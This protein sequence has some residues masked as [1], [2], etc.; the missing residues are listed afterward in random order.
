MYDTLSNLRFWVNNEDKVRKFEIKL[1]AEYMR[2]QI[3]ECQR[4][5]N[6]CIPY[7]NEQEYLALSII[8][9]QLKEM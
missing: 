9:A 6:F 5:I 7:L 8:E 4:A 2:E 3:K 1:E